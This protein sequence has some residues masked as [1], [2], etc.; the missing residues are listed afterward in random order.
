MAEEIGEL[1]FIGFSLLMMSLLVRQS[2]S[3]IDLLSV[4]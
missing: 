2:G 4:F 1:A 3:P